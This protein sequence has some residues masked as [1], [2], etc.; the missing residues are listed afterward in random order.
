VKISTNR[1]YT[2]TKRMEFLW[3]KFLSWLDAKRTDQPSARHWKGQSKRRRFGW[4]QR[5]AKAE[6][7]R[8]QKENWLLLNPLDLSLFGY[9]GNWLGRSLEGVTGRVSKQVLSGGR[10]RTAHF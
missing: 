9:L 6:R 2:G 10:A 5:G 7:S 3:W 4:K 8:I 1:S